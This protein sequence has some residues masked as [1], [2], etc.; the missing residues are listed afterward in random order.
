MERLDAE[1]ISQLLAGAAKDST[2][3][4]FFEHPFPEGVRWTNGK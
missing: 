4:R 1:A 2:P 3:L